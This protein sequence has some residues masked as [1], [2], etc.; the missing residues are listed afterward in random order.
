MA[1]EARKPPLQLNLRLRRL[2][3]GGT[4]WTRV[5][6]QLL[7]LV[8]L[9]WLCFEIYSNAQANTGHAI[10]LGFFNQTAGFGI[11]QS[12]ISYSESD[13]YLT[14]FYVGLL[15][16]LLVAV[17]GIFFATII[18][19][20]V[21]LGRLSPNWLVSRV[22]GGYVELIRN[23]PLLFQ[24]LF[25]YLAVLGT[26]PNPRQ[27]L[28]FLGTF[29][30]NNRGLIV[31]KAVPQ[32]GFSAFAAAV[33]AAIIASIVLHHVARHYLFKT[34]R[35]ITVWPYALG[36]L[37]G[38][39]MIASL[40]FGK[41]ISF[42][43]PVL[44]GFNFSG[45]SRIIPEFVALTVALSTYTAAFIAEVVR[46]G[47]L[48]VHKGQ[49]EAGASLGPAGGAAASFLAAFRACFSWRRSMSAR[50]RLSFAIVV[51]FLELDAIRD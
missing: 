4:G 3:G 5:V 15:N 44:R 33:L 25:W 48:S 42:E 19:F 41:P 14:V 27:S 10:G 6:A 49:M 36:L 39:P 34:G 13:T 30:L 1:I 23:L 28:A 17:V 16:T 45:G 2:L 20:A 18:G 32:D 31:P 12:L 43:M 26:L 21:G 46:A 51:L 8:F 50:S 38:L 29:F 35:K 40:V 11:S 7:F 22:S 24:I 9:I 37:V 47:I